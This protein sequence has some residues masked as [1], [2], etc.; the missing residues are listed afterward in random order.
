MGIVILTYFDNFAKTCNTISFFQKF[1]FPL[2]V[3][4]IILYKHRR[5]RNVILHCGKNDLKRTSSNPEKGTENI[6]LSKSMK[7]DKNNVII[8][9]LNP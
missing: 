4:F 9:E 8:S 2:M 6:N 3:V 7:A 1:K 5:A